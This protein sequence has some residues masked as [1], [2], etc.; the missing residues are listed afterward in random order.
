ML[1]FDRFTVKHII[2]R[3]PNDCHQWLSDSFRVRQIRFRPGLSH[4]P[5]WGSLQRSPDP[6]AGLRDHNSKGEGKRERV[7][8]ETK[9][10]KKGNGRDRPPSQ[11]S[12][13]TPGGV[14]LLL[15]WASVP[16]CTGNADVRE[17][18]GRTPGLQYEDQHFQIHSPP[19]H[20]RH[21]PP[22]TVIT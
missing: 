13:S 6:L 9:G 1:N 11:I 10:E 8:R 5:H 18:R 14:P 20:L 22:D 2:Q 12:G 15:S 7:E 17:G 19:C 4:G 16:G 21:C 3:I